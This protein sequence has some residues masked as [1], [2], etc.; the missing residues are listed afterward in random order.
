M[1]V[2]ADVIPIVAK[3]G[4]VVRIRRE[5]RNTGLSRI[6]KKPA[7]K[8]VIG[9]TMLKIQRLT[10]LNLRAKRPLLA[11]LDHAA[12][13]PETTFCPSLVGFVFGDGRGRRPARK[14][15]LCGQ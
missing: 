13:K 3:A 14:A 9:F 2:V 12:I 6:R 7:T 4:D 10:R 11:N 5:Q 8:N 15:V 1:G